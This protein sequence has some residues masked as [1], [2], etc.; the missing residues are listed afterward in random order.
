M[1]GDVYVIHVL[2]GIIHSPNAVKIPKPA[3]C[4]NGFDTGVLTG[5]FRYPGGQRW[6]IQ[7]SGFEPLKLM[8][9]GST[10]TQSK[11]TKWGIAPVQMHR[12][13]LSDSLFGVVLCHCFSA[14]PFSHG[15]TNHTA[16]HYSENGS[17]CNR[18]IADMMLSHCPSSHNSRTLVSTSL[19]SG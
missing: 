1:G 9:F 7:R 8:V 2:G 19:T 12:I 3:S 15:S 18:K 11:P 16:H 5:L 14:I 13:S 17:C 6:L 4:R 10:N